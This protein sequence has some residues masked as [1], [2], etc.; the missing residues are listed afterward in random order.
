M[1]EI[2]SVLG[3]GVE[4][5]LGQIPG[6]VRRIIGSL[7]CS[8]GND[9][10]CKGS[11]DT[12]MPISHYLAGPKKDG[13]TSRAQVLEDDVGTGWHVELDRARTR[14]QER[15]VQKNRRLPRALF[16]QHR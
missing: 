3:R 6:A 8:A 14:R 2:H 1:G 15:P 12:R 7:E 11:K 16:A 10:D 5:E 13:P 4:M 9:L